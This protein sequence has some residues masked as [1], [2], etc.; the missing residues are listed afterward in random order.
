MRKKGGI[1]IYY[2]LISALCVFAKKMQQS[3]RNLYFWGS[4]WYNI[5]VKMQA[6]YSL[7]YGDTAH[8]SEN[9]DEDDDTVYE[10]NFA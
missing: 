8:L 2:L 4:I 10:Q 5:Q 3:A 7:F 6:G 1:N 9:G